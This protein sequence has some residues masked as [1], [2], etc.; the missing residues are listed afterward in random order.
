MGRQILHDKGFPS[1][2]KW[3]LFAHATVCLWENTLGG[4]N[5]PCKLDNLRLR[6]ISRVEDFNELLTGGFDLLWYEISV[7]ECKERL[8][9]GATLFCA[10][11]DRDVAHV[12][13]SGTTRKSYS[14]FYSFPID[15]GYEASIGG[16][17]TAPKYRG[18]GIYT[19]VYSQIFQYLREKGYSKCVFETQKDNIAIHKAQA[20]LGSS[21]WGEG[22]HLRLLLLL[23]FRRVRPCVQSA[24][25]KS[26]ISTQ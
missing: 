14:D 1:L 11:V 6:I 19:Y 23:N 24:L 15:Y 16:T 12:S 2:V 5:I 9:K 8:G 18:K 10:L 21:I 4:P 22:Q 20:K 7:Q 13:W 17:M 25:V 26:S 3:L